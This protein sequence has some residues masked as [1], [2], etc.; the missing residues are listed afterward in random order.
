MKISPSKYLGYIVAGYV[1]KYASRNVK[2]AE[3]IYVTI[4]KVNTYGK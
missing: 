1:A 3:W 4:T 2:V